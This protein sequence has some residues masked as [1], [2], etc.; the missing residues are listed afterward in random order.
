[1]TSLI[2]G[3][4]IAVVA[5]LVSACL[6]ALAGN[7]AVHISN[8]G[9]PLRIEF[10]MAH[11]GAGDVLHARFT[12]SSKNRVTFR[13]DR[14]DFIPADGSRYLVVGRDYSGNSSISVGAN[15]SSVH[16]LRVY[17]LDMNKRITRGDRIEAQVIARD[18]WKD[19]KVSAVAADSLKRLTGFMKNL[20]GFSAQEGDMCMVQ[21]S[22]WSIVSGRDDVRKKMKWEDQVDSAPN[23]GKIQAARDR[24][25]PPPPQPRPD[26]RTYSNAARGGEP[27]KSTVVDTSARVA[28][29]DKAAAPAT[30]DNKQA[31]A[32]STG[33]QSVSEQSKTQT[34]GDEN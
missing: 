32:K 23:A 34:Y 12:N 27:T 9:E 25:A 2:R 16:V 33:K 30:N 11:S 31:N 18:N 10:R 14:G 4:S 26:V 6:A 20:S 1:M 7:G 22:I 28:N 3:V 13:I 17:Q 21:A 29:K 24:L 15:S 5:V 8:L 19:V